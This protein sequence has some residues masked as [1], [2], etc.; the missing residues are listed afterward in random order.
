MFDILRYKFLIEIEVR[1]LFGFLEIEMRI[2]SK[3]KSRNE[4]GKRSY[5]KYCLK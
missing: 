4:N 5:F 1:K 2:E 3:L